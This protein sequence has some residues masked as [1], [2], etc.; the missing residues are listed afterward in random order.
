MERIRFPWCDVVLELD[1]VE[2]LEQL[3]WSEE[4]LKPSPNFRRVVRWI[5]RRL[6]E[7]DRSF[8]W[9]E[10][11]RVMPPNLSDYRGR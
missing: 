4:D 7:G 6:E 5:V 11:W 9:G 1:P 10:V 2:S 3:E 8:L